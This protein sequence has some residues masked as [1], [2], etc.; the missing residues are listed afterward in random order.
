M[1]LWAAPLIAIGVAAA[2]A[3]APIPTTGVGSA[4][5]VPLQVTGPASNRF[6]LVIAGDG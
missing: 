1:A 2:P 3:R 4:T 5:V 6:N